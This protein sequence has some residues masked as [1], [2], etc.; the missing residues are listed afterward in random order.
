MCQLR[1]NSGFTLIE[2]LIVVA[3][4]GIL[5]AIAIPQISSYRARA[6]NGS[7]VADLRTIKAGI[8][9]FKAETAEYPS[10]ISFQ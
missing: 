10:A 5:I 3:I 9:A 2:V 4:M 6:Y 8:E 7:A 1:R